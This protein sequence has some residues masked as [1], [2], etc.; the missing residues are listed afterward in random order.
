MPA[1]PTARPAT[2]PS[3]AEQISDH[4]AELRGVYGT[5]VQ[6]DAAALLDALLDTA[7]RQGYPRDDDGLGWL[8]PAA[9]ST[10]AAAYGRPAVDRTTGE[11]AELRAELRAAFTEQGLTVTTARDWLA[12]AVDVED[13][14]GCPPWARPDGIAVA[15]WSNTC[16]EIQPN[17]SRAMRSVTLVAPAT[18]DGAR[19]V[20]QVV[21][22]I[23]TGARPD[24]FRDR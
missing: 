19:D 24:P 5:T 7:E 11:L 2:P 23:A 6:A 18:A 22:A 12:V 10:A 8:V 17:V 14:P 21:H 9:A 20:A 4:Y 3:S 15:L 13:M 1:L 16:W